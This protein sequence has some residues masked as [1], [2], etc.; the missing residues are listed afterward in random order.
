MSATAT[1]STPGLKRKASHPGDEEGEGEVIRLGAA[2]ESPSPPKRRR[3]S[4]GDE[5][6]VST[7]AA[8][9][10]SA[11]RHRHRGRPGRGREEEEEEDSEAA[12]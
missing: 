10:T 11:E 6:F 2:G 5:A 8:A 4:G 1:P 9:A 12:V 3:I 7:V